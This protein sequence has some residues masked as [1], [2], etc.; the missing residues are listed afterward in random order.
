MLF[1]RVVRVA[2]GRVAQRRLALHRDVVLVVVDFEDG[3][4]GLD[5]PP[6]DD[7][8]NV[9]RIAV[10]VVHLE[11]RAL[12]VP[13]AQRDLALLVERVGP[14]QPGDLRGADVVA[15]QLQDL[16]FVGRHHEEALEQEDPDRIDHERR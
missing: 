4:R 7:R 2:R 11:L 14:S 10:L 16:R 8:G 15:E 6:H 1:V 3:F 12:E 13:H 5:D 9:D